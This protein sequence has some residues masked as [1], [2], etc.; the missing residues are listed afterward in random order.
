MIFARVFGKTAGFQK[1]F[2]E[3]PGFYKGFCKKPMVVTR[4]LVKTH[5]FLQEI[6]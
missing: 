2:N 1:G 6:L 5:G 4:D 3:S